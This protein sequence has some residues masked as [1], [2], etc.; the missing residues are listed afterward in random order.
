MKYCHSCG[1]SI[2]ETAMFCA[3]CGA[4]VPAPPAAQSADPAGPASIALALLPTEPAIQAVPSAVPAVPAAAVAVLE[5]A[6]AAAA[7]VQS[8]MTPA[9]APAAAP[10]TADEPPP[11]TPPDA[12]CPL[13]GEA[14]GDHTHLDDVCPDCAAALAAFVVSDAAEALTVSLAADD[15]AAARGRATAVNAIYSAVADDETCPECRGMDGR[16]T[17]DFETARGW[18]PNARC[19]SPLG[20]RCAVFYEH[21]CLIDGEA[22]E[23][24]GFAAAR[25]LRV[26]P[27]AVAAFHEEK[28]LRREEV[29]LRLRGASRRLS[30]ARGLEKSDPQQAAALYGKAIDALL[31]SSETPLNERRVRHDLPHAFNRLTIVLKAMGHEAEALEEIDRASALGVL[32][33]A[34]CGTKADR[35]AVKARGRRLRERLGASVDA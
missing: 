30:D 20:C 5:A 10:R 32:D 19:R 16:E 28:R 17:T 29:D 27:Q 26:T 2:G 12:A 18:A 14:M 15:G 9:V 34:D 22:R 23:F 7:T 33:R 11:A 4:L 35:E 13:C 24:V 21:E 8:A 1:L 25:G 3:T 6:P 31:T